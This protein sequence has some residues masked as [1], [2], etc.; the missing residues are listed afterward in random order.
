MSESTRFRAR[1]PDVA[2]GGRLFPAWFRVIRLIAAVGAIAALAAPGIRCAP[3]FLE[4][5]GKSAPTQPLRFYA[6]RQAELTLTVTA[7]S[8]V[9]L[10][11]QGD[12]FAA[13]QTMAAPVN[14]EIP[15]KLHRDGFLRPGVQRFNF[16]VDLPAATRRQEFV[17]RLRVR[18]SEAE[19]WLPLPVV[20]LEIVPETWR[21]SLRSLADRIPCGRLAT[22]EKLGRLL[23]QSGARI[24]V[25]GEAGAGEDP[26]RIWFVEDAPGEA[27]ADTPN[28]IL[29]VFK[30]GVPGGLVVKRTGSPPVMTILVDATIL[31]TLEND[32][33]AQEILDRALAAA[34]ALAPASLPQN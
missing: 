17:L 21:T 27:I 33:A 8:A 11:M 1:P 14:T 26:V 7:A 29:I 3:L 34:E 10:Q 28:G 13:A 15:I 32:P 30:P 23:V 5:A 24:H 12:L 20:T 4:I 2:D 22:Q 31:D 16:S 25:A 6:T 19:S 18:A 9:E